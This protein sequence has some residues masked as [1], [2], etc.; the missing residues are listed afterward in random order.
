MIEAVNTRARG[1]RTHRPENVEVASAVRRLD[2]LLLGAVGS[3]VGYGLWSIGGITAHDIGGNPNYY[4]V[5][6]SVYAVVGCVGLVA[7]L[8]VDPDHYR[9]FRQPIFVGTA[10]VMLLVLLGGTVS[11]HSKRWLDIGFFRFQPS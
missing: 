9:R 7:A 11:R 3:L 4:L 5:R 2:W 6:Q 10:G 8:F 1:L